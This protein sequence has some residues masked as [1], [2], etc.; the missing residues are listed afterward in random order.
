MAGR[1][2]IFKELS[3]GPAQPG[4]RAGIGAPRG[5]GWYLFSIVSPAE[6]QMVLENAYL[7]SLVAGH[8]F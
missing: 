2:L 7:A 8:I 5:Q 1:S 6:C 4:Q 3:L